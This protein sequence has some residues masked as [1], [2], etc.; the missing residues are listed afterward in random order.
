MPKVTVTTDV[1]SVKDEVKKPA[2]GNPN[3]GNGKSGNS[4]GR[5]KDID[6]L[7]KLS[8]KQ[9]REREF[10]MLLR[11]IRPHLAD[12]IVTAA[13]IMKNE[14]AA[15]QNKLKAA[16]ILLDQYVKL[17]KEMYNGEEDEDAG[18]EIQQQNAPVFSLK[19][20]DNENKE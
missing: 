13:A 1:E 7:E 19:V 4:K 15:D 10:L 14:K 20:I 2:R 11:K 5:P 8:R 17:V 3:W 6:R 18:E 12:S 9:L 16:S